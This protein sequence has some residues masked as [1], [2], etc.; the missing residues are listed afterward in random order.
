MMEALPGAELV[1][2]PIVEVD[3]ALGKKSVK[4]LEKLLRKFI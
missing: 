4:E 1:N 3:Y 2:K